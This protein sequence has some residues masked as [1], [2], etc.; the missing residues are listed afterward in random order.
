MP[1]QMIGRVN[2]WY[3]KLGVAGIKLTDRLTVGDRIHILGHTSNFEQEV[4]S[5]QI[6]HQDVSQ[7]GPGDDVG[8]RVKF[9]A[10]VGD[11]VYKV[12]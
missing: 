12:T 1:E 6:M 3:G 10:R 2:H 8:I 4:T 9:R 7:A 5:M 11:L